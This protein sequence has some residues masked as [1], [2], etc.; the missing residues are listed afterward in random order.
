MLSTQWQIFASC[1]DDRTVRLWDVESGKCLQV[2]SGHTNWTNGV[3]FHPNGKW[4]LSAAWDGAIKLWDVSSG[5][6]LTTYYADGGLW[7]IAWHADGER[8]AAAGQR[9]VYWLRMVL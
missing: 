6:C 1:G 4:L 2:M 3:A 9:G 7:S 5:E 8:F